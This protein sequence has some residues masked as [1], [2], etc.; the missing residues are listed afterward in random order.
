MVGCGKSPPIGRRPPV[1]RYPDPGGGIGG[2]IQAFSAEGAFSP[3]SFPSSSYPIFALFVVIFSVD[4]FTERVAHFLTT[5][6]TKDTKEI[7]GR[8]G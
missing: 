2:A 1:E 4:L 3:G 6:D 7:K 8:S 5:K